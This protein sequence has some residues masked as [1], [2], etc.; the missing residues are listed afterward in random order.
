M[1]PPVI[2][3][4]DITTLKVGGGVH[5]YRVFDDAE[6][7]VECIREHDERGETVILIGEGSNI[8][9]SDETFPGTVFA[10]KTC[11]V[12]FETVDDTMVRVTADA[13]VSWDALVAEA[14]DAGLWGLEN[15]SSIPGTVG[16]APVQNIGAYGADVAGVIS[17]LEAYDRDERRVRTLEKDELGFGYRTSVLKKFPG[18][19]AVLRVSFLLSRMP[20]PNLAYKDIT[21]YFGATAATPCL[22][23]VR[24]AV[25][26]IRKGKFPSL[27]LFGTAGSFFLNPTLEKSEA[28]SLAARFPGLPRFEEGERVKIPLAW[29][30]DRVVGAKGMREGGAFVWEK[31]PLVIATED[32]A[33]A[34]DVRMLAG[35]LADRVLAHTGIRIVPEVTFL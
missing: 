32:G 33:T 34:S 5:A 30:L 13:G 23:A 4:K 25:T 22:R 31:Q 6:R 28:A 35:A 24:E 17:H 14:V 10:L 2:S 21:E 18:R 9:P 29:V 16:A 19:F 26:E 11:E 1:H 3:F 8:L 20:R 12:V 7:L 27:A 15:L